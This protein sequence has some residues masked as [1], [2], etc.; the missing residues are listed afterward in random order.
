M[1]ETNPTT[2]VASFLDEL[3]TLAD[4]SP[5]RQEFPHASSFEE[6]I[7]IYHA[8]DILKLGN[9]IEG[10]LTRCLKS[11]PGVFV[12]H[13]AYPA[14]LIDDVTQVFQTTIKEETAQGVSKGDHFGNNIRIWNAF[15]KLILRKPELGIRYYAHP[16]L[17]TVSRS[18]LGPRYQM[19]AQVNTVK[20]GSQAQ[21]PHRDYHL[22]FQSQSAISRFP[23]HAQ[24][25]SQ[26]LTLQGA[27]AHT[28]MPLHSGPTEFL[29]YSQC[30]EEG[31]SAIH[32]DE[33]KRFF[34]ATKTQ[35]PLAK[36]DAV[37]FNPALFH[38]AG[39]NSSDNDRIANLI[40][41]S[42]AFG[43]T[44]EAIDHR[45]I[46]LACYPI[47]REQG[48]TLESSSGL[49][50]QDVLTA[51]ASAYPFPTNLDDDPPI[52]GHA[53]RSLA[54]HLEWNLRK[55]TPVEAFQQSIDHYLSTRRP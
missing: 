26:Y 9:S 15:Q 34:Q 16:V 45:A 47:L 49:K 1:N 3:Q 35:L 17:A 2:E 52:E 21:T 5:S 41:V 31:Y 42:S 11:G 23:I 43:K 32:F 29:P 50:A 14:S 10:E 55:N 30:L 38:A 4:H 40:Q 28:D 27:I 48:L 44:M 37:F 8:S 6:R 7:P 12:I 25:M 20:P 19:T 36:G 51:T 54:D 33:V 39:A 24:I 46:A 53:P 22:G 13:N 18:W